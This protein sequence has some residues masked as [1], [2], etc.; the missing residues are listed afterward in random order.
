MNNLLK[1]V[2]Y[3]TVSRA[4][5]FRFARAFGIVKRKASNLTVNRIMAL[6]ADKIEAYAS[7]C[8]AL[9]EVSDLPAQNIFNIDETNIQPGREG[10]YSVGLVGLE[11]RK[12]VPTDK[13][14]YTMIAAIS[15]VGPVGLFPI[16]KGDRVPSTWPHP[17]AMFRKERSYMDKATFYKFCAFLFPELRR[18]ADPSCPIL[19]VMDGASVHMGDVDVYRLAHTHNIIIMYFPP[20]TSSVT[21][22]LDSAALFGSFKNEL[23]REV[24]KRLQADHNRRFGQEEAFLMCHELWERCATP[25]AVAAAFRNTGLFPFDGNAVRHKAIGSKDATTRSLTEEDAK[26]VAEALLA[27]SSPQQP[28]T[29][30]GKKEIMRQVSGLRTVQAVVKRSPSDPGPHRENDNG[31]TRPRK[32]ARRSLSDHGRITGVPKHPL[33]LLEATEN[34]ELAKTVRVTDQSTTTAPP[35]MTALPLALQTGVVSVPDG[36]LRVGKDGK[37]EFCTACHAGGDLVVCCVPDCPRG[38]CLRCLPMPVPG[39]GL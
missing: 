35:S 30:G 23:Y 15:P 18:R 22:P 29:R 21:Q 17:G 14:S 24:G 19:L 37:A 38:L 36:R 1:E 7:V 5:Y 13:S 16:F 27:L 31:T 6:S 2:G 20:N 39:E 34:Y 4:T 32:R 10:G 26:D 33:S 12:T 28:T 3:A 11:V 9:A 25:K 8:D